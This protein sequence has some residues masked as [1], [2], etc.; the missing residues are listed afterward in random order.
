[1]PQPP[2]PDP[3]AQFRS[4]PLFSAE[5][6][7]ERV[8]NTYH[9]RSQEA[10]EVLRGSRDTLYIHMSEEEKQRI[11]A[12]EEK[13]RRDENPPAPPPELNAPP[14]EDDGPPHRSSRCVN[15]L[16]NTTRC[17]IMSFNARS[18][19]RRL[20]E[21][22]QVSHTEWR[23][24]QSV[25]TRHAALRAEERPFSQ[26][27]LVRAV[28]AFVRTPLVRRT[29]LVLIALALCAFF[30]LGAYNGLEHV[31]HPHDPVHTAVMR[32]FRRC[33]EDL[34]KESEL[35]VGLVRGSAVCIR[36]VDKDGQDGVRIFVEP[37]LVDP[38]V[39]TTR[40]GSEV[41]PC[42]ASKPRPNNRAWHVTVS[43]VISVS[44]EVRVTVTLCCEAA[45]RLQM[46]VAI[47]RYPTVWG[48]TRDEIS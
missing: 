39:L 23:H 46:M 8:D 33:A 10:H 5:P 29:L 19:I 13:K 3:L 35:I 25:R 1:V 7:G 38:I 41:A 24:I 4:K 18:T 6:V 45:L 16:R 34:R 26:I 11:A 20:H 14:D 37:K 2:P 40:V 21:E 42:A 27:E 17:M 15:C 12:E 36:D 43:H 31:S 22:F 32:D 30:L 47:K 28:M 9:G 44:P 48:C